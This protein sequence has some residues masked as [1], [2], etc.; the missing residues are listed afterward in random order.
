MNDRFRVWERFFRC[1]LKAAGGLVPSKKE[2]CI[3]MVL[4]SEISAIKKGIVRVDGSEL[5]DKC[6]QKKDSA[7]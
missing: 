1:F 7:C 4:I 5:R 6:H 2:L 3:L